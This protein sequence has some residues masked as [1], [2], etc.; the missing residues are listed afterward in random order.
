MIS[1]AHVVIYS[2]D[3]ETDRAFFRD[4]LGFASVDAGYGWLI[5][6]YLHEWRPCAIQQPL[7]KLRR[8]RVPGENHPTDLPFRV[9]L[10]F[11]NR[12]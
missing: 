7:R 1:G 9:P 5:L 8:Q 6:A 12:M 2:N 4:V 11:R 10:P 3:A